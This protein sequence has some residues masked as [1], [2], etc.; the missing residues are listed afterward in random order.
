MDEKLKKETAPDQTVEAEVE[1]AETTAENTENAF[2]KEI[3]TLKSTEDDFQTDALKINRHTV[4]KYYDMIR[5]EIDLQRREEEPQRR[6]RQ[7]LS[8]V[9]LLPLLPFHSRSWRRVYR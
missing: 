1:Q 5:A 3:E 8:R 7:P 6:V 4:C 9:L 2:E